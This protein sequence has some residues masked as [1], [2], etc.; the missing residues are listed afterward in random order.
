M[1]LSKCPEWN[2]EMRAAYA[3]LHLSVVHSIQRAY[4]D[5]TKVSCLFWDASKFAWSYTITQCDPDELMKPWA[6]Q[7]H[8]ILVTRSGLFKGAQVRWGIGCKE[9][10]PPWRAT[11]KDGHFLRG[12]FPWIAAGDHRN[13]TY[14]QRKNKRSPGLGKASVDR[15]DRWC[16]D[17]SHEDFQVYTLPGEMNLFN[18]FHT[19]DGA[20]DAAPFLTLAEHEER[21]ARKLGELEVARS[22]H[23]TE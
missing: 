11:Q 2:E 20:P 15:L 21:L 9:A 19:R 16:H 18:D 13:I 8:Q 14:V 4:R 22:R 12:C 10:Y 23:T 5:Y 17:W 1:K 3:R 6:E 7:Q